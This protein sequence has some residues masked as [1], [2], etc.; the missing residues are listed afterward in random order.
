M[1]KTGKKNPAGGWLR[2]RFFVRIATAGMLLMAVVGCT[3]GFVVRGLPVFDGPAGTLASW[4]ATGVMVLAL[5]LFYAYCRRVGASWGAGLAAERQIGDPID[6]AV[7]RRGC[8][9]AHDVKEAL[10]G[11][12][13]VDH[14]V[15]TPAGIWVVETK[16]GLAEQEAVCFSAGP[17]EEERSSGPKPSGDVPPGAW[18][19]GDCRQRPRLARIA[20]R[21]EGR[22][23][24][25]VRREEVLA[26]AARGVRPC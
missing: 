13:N 4:G 7:A 21:R 22:A 5:G 18:C 14:V 23:G 16:S 8:A 17:G 10:G 25:G 9:V 19:P 6:H 11:R 1:E 15:M 20:V 3:L 12:G 26:G 2:E 24:A